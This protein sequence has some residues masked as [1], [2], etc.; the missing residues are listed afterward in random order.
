MLLPR[1][2]WSGLRCSSYH[3]DQ[4]SNTDDDDRAHSCTMLTSSTPNPLVHICMTL[5]SHTR[6]ANLTA[7][8]GCAAREKSNSMLQHSKLHTSVFELLDFGN[9]THERAHSERTSHGYHAMTAVH[10]TRTPGHVTSTPVHDASIH[11]RWRGN[12]GLVQHRDHRQEHSA[13]TKPGVRPPCQSMV[14]SS[15][16]LHS[17]HSTALTIQTVSGSISRLRVPHS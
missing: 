14:S 1:R 9:H 11:I 7:P 4:T 10:T 15:T 13:A 17:E 6:K 16:A 5:A 2:N 3:H 12:V 8:Q